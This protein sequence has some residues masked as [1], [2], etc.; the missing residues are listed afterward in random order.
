MSLNDAL[1]SVLSQIDNGV[2]VGKKEIVT[3]VS[4]TLIKQV[5]LIMK[6]NGYIGAVEELVDAKGNYLRVSL[7]GMLNKCGVIKPRF[8]VKFADFEKYEKR[9]L[10]AKGFG[11]LLVSTNEGLLTHVEAKQKGIGGRLISYCY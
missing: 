2:K 11:F 7:L 9:F 10:P 3:N 6:E 4:S 5:L 1:A 8:S